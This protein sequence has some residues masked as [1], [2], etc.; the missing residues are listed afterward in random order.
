[1]PRTDSVTGRV[2][3]LKD[4]ELTCCASVHLVFK[5][6]AG[7]ALKLKIVLVGSSKLANRRAIVL[8]FKCIGSVARKDA[9]IRDHL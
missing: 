1:M 2:A 4:L 7:A 3:F 9:L 8:V 6:H 5:S